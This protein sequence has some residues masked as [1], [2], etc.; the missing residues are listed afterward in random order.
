MTTAAT[1]TPRDPHL[2]ARPL[3]IVLDQAIRRMWPRRAARELL[4]DLGERKRWVEV[5]HEDAIR[6]LAAWLHD[7]L[8]LP[9]VLPPV[10]HAPPPDP[11]RTRA[12]GEALAA[13]PHPGVA[14]W[15][16]GLA[17]ALGSTPKTLANTASRG[18]RADRTDHRWWR[19]LARIQD[20]DHPVE[21][22]LFHERTPESVTLELASMS[23]RLDHLDA[24][25]A[26][27]VVSL[28][29]LWQRRRPVTSVS[30]QGTVMVSPKRPCDL[31]LRGASSA[32]SAHGP[33]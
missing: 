8:S 26:V 12:M 19:L 29:A 28:I 7:E 32:A 3:S 20:G 2:P 9:E 24:G 6:R 31:L 4:L 11:V 17:T 22:W 23:A 13:D 16:T 10:P 25:D 15:A 21:A 5:D 18:I 30:R 27:L 14:R 33:G 1:M